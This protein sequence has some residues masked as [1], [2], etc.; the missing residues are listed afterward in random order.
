[1]KKLG[2]KLLQ[3]ISINGL[4]LKNRISMAPMY[5]KYA[6]ESGEVS[7]KLIEYF[8]RRAKNGVAL[9]ILENTCIE[10]EQ[11][12]IYGNPVA[13]YDDRFLPALNELVKAVHRYGAKIIP[14]IHHVGRQV[15]SSNLNGKPPL[16]P[17]AVKS[18]VGGDMPKKM[19]EEEI[20]ATIKAFGDAALR[21]KKAEFDGVEL[22]GAHGYLIQEFI[23]PLTNLRNDKWG[24]SFKNRCRFAVE[25]IRDI[26]SKVGEDF[27]LFFRFSAEESS[28]GGL[29]LE[30]GLKY[31]KVLEAEGVDCLDVTHGNYESLKHF[32][33]QGDSFDQLIYLSEAVKNDVSIPVIAVGSLGIKPEIAN[34]VLEEKKADLINIGRELLADS[35]FAKKVA[36]NNYDE[37]RTCLR[38]NE[39]T[40][41]V[42][43]G[44]YLACAVNPELGY[45]YKNLL[46]LSQDP[47][48]I[49]VVGAGPAGLEYSITA[50]KLGHKV[51]ILEKND[52]I[53]GLVKI[54][55]IPAY[56]N[57]E[58]SGLLKYYRTMLK[59]LA[60]NLKLSTKATAD[61]IEEYSPDIVVLAV[62]SKAIKLP[63]KGN[64][65]A[66][67]AVDKLADD[68]Q[69]LGKDICVIGGSGVGIDTAMFL[70][71]KNKNVKIIEM[72]SEIAG[73][74]SPML[75][76]HLKKVVKEND[77]EVLTS[78]LVKEI[79][80]NS[81][82]VE[83][84]DQEKEINC[85][86]ILSAVGFK[87]LDTTEME[88]ELEKKGIKVQKLRVENG[89]GHIM[90]ATRNGFWSALEIDKN[91]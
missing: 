77:I 28:A 48:N 46:K 21:A 50:A 30:E 61:I 63:L 88:K 5:T 85:D 53:G 91:F 32:P 52:Q 64:E 87:N 27:P 89:C 18:K 36:N 39:C 14:E 56:K 72:Q 47:K 73:E 26:R 42:D 70:R 51:T 6:S 79:K 24:G 11:G 90:D 23:S 4:E 7:D 55:S 1:M 60:I 69:G 59:R 13:I 82:I 9:I 57:T 17:S 29:T 22:H 62:G 2:K 58:F 76:T 16:A 38:C 74:L 66:E 54:A 33:M 71:E 31:A 75:S 3:E 8:A 40:G 81:V 19:T 10:W 35:E 34:N 86:N 12:R 25:I 20:I 44:K 43:T 80:E 37:I 78:H 45:E 67:I 15:F 68:C 41:S 65:H 49:V 84:N 83:H